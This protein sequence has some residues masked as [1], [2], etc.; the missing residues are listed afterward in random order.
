MLT[1]IVYLSTATTLLDPADLDAI[2]AASRRNNS[3]DG[4][5]GLLLYDRGS[6]V[7]AV[8][9]EAQA[10]TVLMQ[11]I[12]QDRRHHSVKIVDRQPAERRLF[13]DWSMGYAE[14]AGPAME[15][16]NRHVAELGSNVATAMLSVYLR[17]LGMVA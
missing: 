11:R 9:G 13:G 12:G 5:T 17:N 3:R 16:I 2:L 7:Q 8:E 14:V 6:I 10:L 15:R 1:R 4:I